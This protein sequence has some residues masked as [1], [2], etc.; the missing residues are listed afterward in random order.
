MADVRPEKASR[1][2]D[3]EPSPQLGTIFYVTVG[4]SGAFLLAG[5]L[6]TEPFGNALAAVVDQI[7]NG[8]GWLYLLITTVFLVFV[9]YLALSRFGRIRLGGRDAKPE[10]GLS[11]WFCMRFQAG[12]GIGLLFWGVA[13]PLLD[14]RHPPL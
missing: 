2:A 10:F 13:E 5:F 3:D 14:Y 7:I 9:L 11:A 1:A 4:I 8:V 12:M 6:F